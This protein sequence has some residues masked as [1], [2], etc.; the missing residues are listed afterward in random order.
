MGCQ[1][2]RASIRSQL[3]CAFDPILRSKLHSYALSAPQ[4]AHL[5][6]IMGRRAHGLVK[7]VLH[8]FRRDRALA[9]SDHTKRR[10]EVVLAHCRD[11]V[12]PAQHSQSRVSDLST[13]EARR[14]SPTCA[15]CSRSHATPRSAPRPGSFFF[16]A[17]WG[18]PRSR[19]SAA[20]SR[21]YRRMGA[22]R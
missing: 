12:V 13:G 4:L 15:V 14:A 11:F 18:R 20:N 10:K 1:F 9:T 5:R 3:L 6:P 16:A 17:R 2:R 19:E 7:H 8:L 21:Q 22:H